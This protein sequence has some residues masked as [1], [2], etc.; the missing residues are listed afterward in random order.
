M[1]LCVNLQK[2]R[3][4]FKCGQVINAGPQKSGIS[5]SNKSTYQMQILDLAFEKSPR[6]AT[7]L[8]I[9]VRSPVCLSVYPCPFT[10]LVRSFAMQANRDQVP[11]APASIHRFRCVVLSSGLLTLVTKSYFDNAICM[12]TC[13][14]LSHTLIHILFSWTFLCNEYFVY[15]NVKCF[16]QCMFYE[17]NDLV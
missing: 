8:Y 16:S 7:G 14:I 15:K 4:S 11:R 9:S 2:K 10:L 3:P 17:A 12:Y 5:C 6:I 1:C 13:D